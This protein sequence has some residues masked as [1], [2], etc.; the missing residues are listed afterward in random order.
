VWVRRGEEFGDLVGEAFGGGAAESGGD[1]DCSVGAAE[2]DEP[3][4]VGWPS[5]GG[6][7][8]GVDLDGDGCG[9][10]VAV[11]AYPTRW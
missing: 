3:G 2:A 11:G 4:P 8:A 5:S 9:V 7:G 10:A 6:G 1:D